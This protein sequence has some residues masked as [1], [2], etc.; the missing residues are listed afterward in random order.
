MVVEDKGQENLVGVGRRSQSDLYPF[1]GAD[2]SVTGEILA[3]E[4]VS[5]CKDSR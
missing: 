2:A 1:T 5:D 4:N 3:R